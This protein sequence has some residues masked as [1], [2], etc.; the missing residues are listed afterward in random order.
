MEIRL[1]LGKGIGEAYEPPKGR[2]EALVRCR[3]SLPG[4]DGQ[5]T[6]VFLLLLLQGNQFLGLGNFISLY[7]EMY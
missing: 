3:R 6:D 2:R 7:R 1:S 4:W 5:E